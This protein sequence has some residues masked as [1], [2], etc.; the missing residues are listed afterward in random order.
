MTSQVL[1]YLFQRYD[2]NF[3]HVG[4]FFPVGSSTA[5]VGIYNFF[6]NIYHV[7]F[8]YM[9]IYLRYY[10][11]LYLFQDSSGVTLLW[12]ILIMSYSGIHL[13]FSALFKTVVEPRFDVV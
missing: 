7:M 10:L 13:F 6:L 5:Q 12:K 9:F 8:S 1:R 2:C 11:L 4:N 3:L